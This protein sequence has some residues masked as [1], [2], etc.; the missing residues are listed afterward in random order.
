MDTTPIEK[1]K[2]ILELS[3]RGVGGEKITAERLLD[4]LLLKHGIN[5]SDLD[6]SKKL[7]V[8]FSFKNEFEKKLA[9]Q[10]C[11]KILNTGSVPIYKVRGK[12]KTRILE[13]TIA[14]KIEFELYYSV[15]R[16]EMAREFEISFS[17][18]IQTNALYR[19]PS[20]DDLCGRELNKDEAES[21]L[22]A[23]TMTAKTINKQVEYSNN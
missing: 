21:L 8:T 1:I 11:T 2:K 15:L 7:D 14:E 12:T 3:K 23:T 17:A 10:I 20:G 13:L 6:D 16:E 22:R 5:L 4:K 19:K 18:F 9:C